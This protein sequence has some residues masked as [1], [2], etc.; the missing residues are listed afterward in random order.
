MITVN[1]A[2]HDAQAC[3]CCKEKA[4]QLLEETDWSQLPDVADAIYN[5]AEFD[6]YR[7]AL[8]AI[9][10]NPVCEPVWPERPVA[11]WR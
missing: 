11:V 2:K 5:K 10:F 6:A 8:R 7:A 9:Y 3:D 1:Q 4:K